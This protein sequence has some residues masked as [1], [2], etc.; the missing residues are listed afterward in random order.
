VEY[1]RNVRSLLPICL[2]ALACHAQ[3]DRLIT[4]P[5][6]TKIRLDTLRIEGMLEQ[7]RNRNSRYY[8]GFGATNA[9]DVEV[10]GQV[11]EGGRMRTSLDISYN[12]IPPIIGFGPGISFGVQDIWGVTRD[13]RRFFV[14]V[15]NKEGFADSVHGFVAAEFTFGA[16]FGGISSPFVGV[17]L[18]FTDQFRVLAEY[19]G[20]R[21]SA[22]IEIR[23]TND[24]GIRAVFEE[25]DVLLGAQISLRF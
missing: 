24:I 18:P 10:T 4:I 12:Y 8:L 23:P 7:S 17:M 25:K 9:F 11:F 16:Y 2:L 1:I 13:G 6:G 20:R 5:T 3:A 19:N 21:I 22:G 15:T 14:A